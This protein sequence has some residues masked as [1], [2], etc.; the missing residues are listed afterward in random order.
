MDIPPLE[1]SS[2]SDATTQNP[3]AS[4][5]RF[6]FTGHTYFKSAIE[7][8]QKYADALEN[9]VKEA[10]ASPDSS[11]TDGDWL[12]WSLR[13]DGTIAKVDEYVLVGRG[14]GLGLKGVTSMA[15]A[16]RFVSDIHEER[17]EF[18]P[19]WN[20]NQPGVFEGIFLH[21]F[22]SRSGLNQFPIQIL[23]VLKT[24]ESSE[25]LISYGLSLVHLLGFRKGSLPDS[26]LAE[27]VGSWIVSRMQLLPTEAKNLWKSE[28]ILFNVLPDPLSFNE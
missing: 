18:W 5:R 16:A 19:E 4:D 7:C 14:L 13:L 1:S 27:D 23:T 12:D 6:A 2:S 15:P 8:I 25:P 24:F 17:R 20:V 3:P 9:F 21:L 28:S 26:S 22:A 11:F 10:E